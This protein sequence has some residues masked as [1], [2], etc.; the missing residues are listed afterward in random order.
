MTTKSTYSLKHG[1][2]LW[3][4]T[5]QLVRHSRRELQNKMQ[6]WAVAHVLLKGT[7]SYNHRVVEWLELE[8]ASKIT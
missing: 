6:F 8:G 5:M 4:K 2:Y 1:G 3:K 7:E